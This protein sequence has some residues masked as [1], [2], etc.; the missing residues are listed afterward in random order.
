M[1]EQS[2]SVLPDGSKALADMARVPT[3]EFSSTSRHATYSSVLQVGANCGA[4]LTFCTTTDTTARV[5]RGSIGLESVA[6]TSM[7]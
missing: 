6:P 2:K 3:G 1:A 7:L 5:V 4:S